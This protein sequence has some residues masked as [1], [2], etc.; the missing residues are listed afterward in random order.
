M[1]T[2]KATCIKNATA[3]YQNTTYNC[4]YEPVRNEIII[5]VNEK[6]HYVKFSLDLFEEYFYSGKKIIRNLKLE[7]LNEKILESSYK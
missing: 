3:L 2:F 5:Y 1:E 4:K 7:K 6:M